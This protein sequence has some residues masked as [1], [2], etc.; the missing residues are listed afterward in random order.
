MCVSSILFALGVWAWASHPTSIKY[1]EIAPYVGTLWVPLYAVLRNATPYLRSRVSVPLE[2]LG[3]RSLE[4]YLLQFH[5]LM[6]RSA[7]RVL[8]LIPEC[9]LAR[10]EFDSMCVSVDACGLEV[11]REHGLAPRRRRGSAA[12]R[13]GRA[14]VAVHD[15]CCCAS[16]RCSVRGRRAHDVVLRLG[17]STLGGYVL[18][19][20]ARRCASEDVS[21]RYSVSATED[22]DECPTPPGSPSIIAEVA[23]PEQ[24]RPSQ[25]SFDLPIL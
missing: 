12:A 7:G 19:D 13:R 10:L 3:A 21:I 11:L 2:W 23:T 6:N 25:G 14:R 1:R 16:L 4:L 8:W 18:A 22:A 15:V 5:L 9:Q 17:G 24:S 20:C